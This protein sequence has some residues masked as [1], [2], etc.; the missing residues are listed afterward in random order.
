M[1]KRAVVAIHDV[2]PRYFAKVKKLRAFLLAEGV[3]DFSYFVIPKFHNI[4]SEDLRRN[5]DLVNF[6]HRDGRDIA[7]HGLTHRNLLLDDEFA[8]ISYR[9]TIQKLHAAK[10]IFSEVGLRSRGF[11]PPMWLMG[12]L[13]LGAVVDEGFQ[14][15]GN[16]KFLYDLKNGQ[17]HRSTLIV[18]GGIMFIPSMLNSTIKARSSPLLQIALH[19]GDSAVKLRFLRRAIRLAKKRG[20]I[21]TSYGTFIDEIS[22]R[23]FP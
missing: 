3:P 11:I 7:I 6:L 18:R 9:K 5:W 13:A 1:E 4:D 19:P 12:R 17:K 21:F 16:Q 8:G 14:Y 22:Q 2:C 20:Y 10:E 23:T 15:T